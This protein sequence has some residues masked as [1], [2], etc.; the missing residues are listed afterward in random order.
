M[1]QGEAGPG[2]VEGKR[3]GGGLIWC[4]RGHP[5]CQARRDS[6]GLI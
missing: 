2:G 3:R 4:E 1:R 6:P 5:V